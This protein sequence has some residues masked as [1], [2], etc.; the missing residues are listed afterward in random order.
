MTKKYF[1]GVAIILVAGAG[2]FFLSGTFR[3]TEIA[4]PALIGILVRGATYTPGVD[5]FKKK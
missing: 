4:H 5:G 2:I 1:I 3:R